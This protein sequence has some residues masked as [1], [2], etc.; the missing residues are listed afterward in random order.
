MTARSCA[1]L[2]SLKL[3][4]PTAH[5]SVG[6]IALTRSSARL[7]IRI[8]AGREGSTS[9]GG[10][11]RRE[12]RAASLPDRS[13]WL[14]AAVQRASGRHVVGA[15]PLDPGRA[16]DGQVGSPGG[17]TP[18]CRPRVPDQRMRGGPC[19]AGGSTRRIGGSV[20]DP[21]DPVGR[22]LFTTLSMIAEFE[23]DLAQAR[24]R[25]G[26][27]VARAKGRLRGK[28]PKLRPRRRRIWSSCTAQA[29]TPSANW[30]KGSRSL[31]PPSTEP[32]PVPTGVLRC[33][34]RSPAPDG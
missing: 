18:E 12:D 17:G 13:R 27:A 14:I 26:M 25:E 15:V 32:S 28:Q 11:A 3:S 23:A 30:P 33:R 5:A 24:T 9:V 16:N 29:R 10:A 22:L 1:P 21:T 4:A 7:P 6:L 34:R 8:P 31:A 2:P 20:H 19:A